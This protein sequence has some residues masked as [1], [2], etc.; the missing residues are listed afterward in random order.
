VTVSSVLWFPDGK[1]LLTVGASKGQAA[2]S[3][4]MDLDG[5]HIQPLGPEAWSAIAISRDGKRIAGLLLSGEK[6]LYDVSTQQAH[7][8]IGIE[9]REAVLRWTEDGQALLVNSATIAD[10]RIF[11]VEVAT[12]K[13]SLLRRLEL[14]DAAGSVDPVRVQV[15]PDNKIYVYNFR[16][17]TGSLYMVEGIH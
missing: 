14:Y 15:G 11:R 6:I 5:G 8:I 1:R 16:R 12:G 4:T 9:P 2:R 10:A 17:I 7:S 3:Y 13:R